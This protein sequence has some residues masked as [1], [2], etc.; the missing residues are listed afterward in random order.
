[1]L[2]IIWA[3]AKL[4]HYLY[5]VKDINIFT[6][7]Q[8]LTFAVS[9]SN[10]NAKIKRWKARIDESGA[11]IF[12]KPAMEEQEAESCIATI[13]SELSL[14]HTID[15]TD[16]PLNCFQNQLVLEEARSPSKRSFIL[17]G[18]KRRHLVS[19]SCKESLLREIADIIV[20]NGVNAI[21][22]DLHTLAMVQDQLVQQFPATKFWYCKNQVT[23]I[24]A[25]AERRE[26]ITAEHNRAHR[27]AQ[28]NVK[29]V[30]SE[31]YFPKM[32]MMTPS[33]NM[34]RMP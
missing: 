20:P 10:P 15:S 6:D 16:K 11:R 5:A 24:F 22:C 1:L 7:H 13:H 27:S 33:Q 23:D 31:Y 26:I 25:V 28:E 34:I 12:Y 14:T 17:L 2:A 8:P 9:E 19:F 30:L 18:N 21:H 32:Q 4:R 29:Q 3:L